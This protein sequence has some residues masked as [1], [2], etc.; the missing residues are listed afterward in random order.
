MFFSNLLQSL[1]LFSQFLRFNSAFHS[2]VVGLAAF[3]SFLLLSSTT[4]VTLSHLFLSSASG[5]LSTS[6]W[7]HTE[8]LDEINV[9]K[10]G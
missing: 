8:R 1:L 10:C 5:T 4:L 2:E 7:V 6:F 9:L 3:S